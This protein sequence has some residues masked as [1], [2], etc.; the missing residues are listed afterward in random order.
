M[1]ISVKGERKTMEGD[2]MAAS[3]GPGA[4]C[5]SFVGRSIAAQNH[6]RSRSSVFFFR[7]FDDPP[8]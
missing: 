3:V 7:G 6:Q 4:H 2:G 8:L 5:L 1:T